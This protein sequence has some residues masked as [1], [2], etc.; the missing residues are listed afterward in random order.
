MSCPRNFIQE[1]IEEACST[2][3]THFLRVLVPNT[4]LSI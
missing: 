1:A 4:L 2:D 3:Q